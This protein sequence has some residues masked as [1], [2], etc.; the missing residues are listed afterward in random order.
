MSMKIVNGVMVPLSPEDISFI[1][2]PLPP[3]PSSDVNKHRSKLI[4]K[5][6]TFSLSSGK[7]IRIQGDQQTRENL[8]ALALAANLRLARGVTK[9]VTPYRDADNVIHRLSPME[10]L[11]LWQ[12]AASFV[13]A[14]YAAS[15]EIKDDP[16]GISPD[17][18][19]DPRWP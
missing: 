7:T 18:K 2:R 10:V 14:V 19:D 1:S 16:N 12:F 9:H 3:P 6:S 17:F 13:E 15:W 5:G 4:L 8:D 11:E